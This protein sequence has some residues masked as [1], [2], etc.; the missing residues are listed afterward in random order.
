VLR[1]FSIGAIAVHPEHA[2]PE[3]IPYIEGTMPVERFYDEGGIVAYRVDLPPW[4]EEWT[5]AP[6]D[7]L[8]RLSYA[9]GWGPPADGIRWA[10]RRMNRLLVPSNGQEQH[11]TFR[12][13][14][15]EGGKRLEVEVNGQTVAWIGLGAGWMEYEISVPASVVR[16]GLNEIW[17]R[18]ETLYPASEIRLSPRSIG[19]GVESPI[20]LVVQSAGQEVG[21]SGHIY[22]NGQEVSPNGR[23]YNIAVIHPQSGQVEGTA[24]FDTHLDEGASQALVA[25][26]HSVPAGHIVA[27]AAADEAS[28]LLGEEA[29]AA[30]QGIGA[31]GDLR[32]L[33]R[34]GHAIIGTQ[35]A[36][37]GT[38]LE[39][40]D[41]MR[42]VTLV[43]GE[44][45]TE[46]HLAAAFAKITLKAAPDQ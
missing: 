11:M 4:P 33:F 14:T 13:Y 32:G 28:R 15:A 19:Q 22:V 45:A 39:A 40:L 24:A 9:E 1:F 10:Q 37:P 35:G 3:A 43:V 41:W 26:L 36:P 27:V 44:G 30:L 7:E 25:F 29:V 5:I 31:A 21:D 6:D 34:W 18:F 42:P 2:G 38:A 12:A 8:G 17:L 46:P 16:Q 23:G 20:N